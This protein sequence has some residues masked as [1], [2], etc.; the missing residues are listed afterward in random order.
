[1]LFIT[2]NPGKAK[3]AREILG[4]RIVQKDI[5]LQEIRADRVEDVAQRKAE[6]AYS[7]LKK[8]LI[9]EDS[10]LFIKALNGFPGTCSSYVFKT[11]GIKGILKL[12]EGVKDRKAEFRCAVGYA[13]SK[14]IKVF[15]GTTEGSIALHPKGKNGFGFDPI[16]IPEG[17]K[18][19][20]AESIVLK[21]LSSHRHNAL[22]Q[23]A[24]YMRD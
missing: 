11:I 9:V 18:K 5:G 8:P 24:L 17:S 21:N 4:I 12:M 19:T 22:K 13:S 1:M 6:D 3:E 20:Y 10:G 7:I 23:L 14:G 16:F 2:G 15:V